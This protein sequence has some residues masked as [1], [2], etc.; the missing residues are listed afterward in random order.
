MLSAVNELDVESTLP[1]EQDRCTALFVGS[2]RSV[3]AA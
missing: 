3:K 1:P 2:P